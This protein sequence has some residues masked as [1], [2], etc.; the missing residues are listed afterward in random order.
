[1]PIRLRR[2]NDASSR[3]VDVAQETLYMGVDVRH[4]Q[5]VRCLKTEKCI[6]EW[7]S[8]RYCKY[9]ILP[10][11]FKDS[12][13]DSSGSPQGDDESPPSD[14]KSNGHDAN[15]SSI[16]NP[17]S[18]SNSRSG[19]RSSSEEHGSRGSGSKSPSGSSKSPSKSPSSSSE[20]HGS[21]KGDKDVEASYAAVSHFT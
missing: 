9:S 15:R 16:S 3:A 12:T 11:V 8:P 1:M 5:A 19:S 10:M 17:R 7:H 2:D 13:L 6:R 21:E 18:S 4:P 14:E 20:S